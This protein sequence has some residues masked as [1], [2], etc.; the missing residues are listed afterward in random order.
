MFSKE[1][2]EEYVFDY[3]DGNMPAEQESLFQAFLKNHPDLEEEVMAIRDLQLSAV[4]VDFPGKDELFRLNKSGHGKILNDSFEQASVAYYEGDLDQKQKQE[5]ETLVQNN[6]AFRYP[7]ESFSKAFLKPDE[8]IEFT[9]KSSLKRLTLTQKRTRIFT[10]ISSAAAVIILLFV[11]VNPT[12]QEIQTITTQNQ[13]NQIE[14]IRL[15]G[16][17]PVPAQLISREFSGPSLNI[18]VNNAVS[19]RVPENRPDLS[20]PLLATSDMLI[21]NQVKSQ[22]ITLSY[23]TI[24]EIMIPEF[25]SIGDIT[26]ERLFSRIFNRESENTQGINTFW[27]LAMNGIEGLSNL[28]DGDAYIARE[29]NPDGEVERIIFETDVF[30]FSAPARND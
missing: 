22:E 7:F 21:P 2:F 9:G 29:T 13:G 4:T 16:V 25:L 28:T 23:E 30:G 12:R 1:N 14:I 8:T 6:D 17:N 19:E 5:L 11:F 15:P 26:R 27:N 10:I 24:D 18:I 3:L 20:L